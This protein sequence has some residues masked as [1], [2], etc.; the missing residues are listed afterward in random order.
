M[1]CEV[2]TFV[3]ILE[4]RLICSDRY[5]YDVTL[6]NENWQRDI[7]MLEAKHSLFL[8]D[9]QDTRGWSPDS[10]IVVIVNKVDK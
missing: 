3:F 4:D 9:N 6:L 1:S 8:S 10:A 7:L 5:A 2:K